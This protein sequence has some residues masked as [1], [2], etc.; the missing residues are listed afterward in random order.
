MQEEIVLGDVEYYVHSECD[1]WYLPPTDN[2][3]SLV[4]YSLTYPIERSDSSKNLE[5]GLTP[6][7]EPPESRI[8]ITQN[9]DANNIVT[10]SN[11]YSFSAVTYCLFFIMLV[12]I[13]WR[14]Q[15][16]NLDRERDSYR[17]ITHE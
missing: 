4:V 1:T 5:H 16:V 13:I 8:L 3:D 2:I 17:G 12:V 7:T 6:E 15:G 14:Y 9:A 10:D 11:I